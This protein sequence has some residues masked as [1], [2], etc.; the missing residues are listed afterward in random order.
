MV[1][2]G[3][4]FVCPLFVTVLQPAKE[5]ATYVI[6]DRAAA[7]GN[8]DLIPQTLP[9]VTN[10]PTPTNTP[11]TDPTATPVPTATPTPITAT[12][13]EKTP[14]PAATPAPPGTG[15]A[16]VIRGGRQHGYD[17][18]TALLFLCA[19]GAGVLALRK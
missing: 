6:G 12:E 13:G 8:A 7:A 3:V 15:N 4:T 5:G 1:P 18:L 14:G 10:T 11:K 19:L 2:P 9:S 17:A 16:I